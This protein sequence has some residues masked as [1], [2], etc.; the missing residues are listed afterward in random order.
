MNVWWGYASPLDGVTDD[1]PVLEDDGPAGEVEKLEE[2]PSMVSVP[3]FLHGMVGRSDKYKVRR[4]LIVLHCH[5]DIS[6]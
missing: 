3:A 4:S 2:L 5:R 6:S 1:L